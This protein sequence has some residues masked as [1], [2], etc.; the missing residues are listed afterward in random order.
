V[1]LTQLPADLDEQ[2]LVRRDR[3][4]HWKD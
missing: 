3:C 1:C 4:W 2:Q